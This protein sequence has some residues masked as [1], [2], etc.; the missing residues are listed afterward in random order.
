MFRVS[1]PPE[2][3]LRLGE[4]FAE[5][6]R[7]YG[8][9]IWPALG[10]GA[11]AAGSLLLA[12]YSPPLVAVL[13]VALTFT[14]CYGAAA[15]VV[16]GDDFRESWAHVAVQLPVLLVLTFVVSLPYGLALGV[17]AGDAL[18]QLVIVLFAIAWLVFVGFSIPVSVVETAHEG[19][20][21]R[22]AHALRRSVTLARA[23]FF[24]AVGVAAALLLVYAVLGPLLASALVG[25]AE[26]GIAAA[27][28][29]AQLVLAPFFFLGLAVLYF[30]Q[31]ARALS[32]RGG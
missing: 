28:T 18:A 23:E 24:H 17:R 30:E 6:V 29:L 5:T 20:F 21:S 4:V 22:L 26:N 19:W 2:R 16:S 27:L 8:E 7:L 12:V 32:S 11:V 15:R 10:I 9:R 25:F 14:A 31:R 13:L 3:P 1:T